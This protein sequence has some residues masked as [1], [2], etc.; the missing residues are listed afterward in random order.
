MIEV[1]SGGI[2]VSVSAKT[3]VSD[4]I[5]VVGDAAHQVNPIHGGGICLAMNAAK[6]AGETVIA[7]ISEGDTSRSR[8]I[9]YENKWHETDGA[10][11]KRLMKLR[12]FIETLD[13][14]SF[15]KLAEILTGEDIMKLITETDL[16]IL[17]KVFIQKAPGML[18]LAKK[19]LE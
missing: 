9:E 4:G 14:E 17:L 10:K 19:Y 16:K 18:T 2:P 15:E 5:V 11:M 13:D 3:F 6:M 7:A 12:H 1:N 8:L